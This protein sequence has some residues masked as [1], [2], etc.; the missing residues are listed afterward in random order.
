MTGVPPI[1]Y[2]SLKALAAAILPQS[3]ASSTM[4]VNTSTVAISARPS[5]MRHAAASSPVPAETSTSSGIDTCPSM[6]ITVPRS[7]GPSLHAHPAPWLN[8]V[9]RTSDRIERA[10]GN[11]PAST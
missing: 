2:T 7:A 6:P 4:G 8:A 10:Y 3:Y 11:T 5:P 9:S 1:A